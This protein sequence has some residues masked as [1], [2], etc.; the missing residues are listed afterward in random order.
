MKATTIVFKF[1]LD[2]FLTIQIFFNQ[3]FLHRRP[4]HHDPDERA[5]LQPHPDNMEIDSTIP[6]AIV[7]QR[8][9][10]SP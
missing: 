2:H 10:L 4:P 6:Q 5:H 3:G 8:S 1:K 9:S 7:Q